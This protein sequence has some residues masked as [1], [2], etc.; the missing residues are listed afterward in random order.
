MAHPQVPPSQKVPA[1]HAASHP[2]QWSGLVC[3]STHAPLHIAVA[4]GHAQRPPL[5]S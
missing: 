3:V 2:P 4:P 5:H 1:G